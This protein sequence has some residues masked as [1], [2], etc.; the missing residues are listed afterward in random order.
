MSKIF[1]KQLADHAFN[2]SAPPGYANA[3]LVEIGAPLSRFKL[4]TE[5]QEHSDYIVVNAP[6]WE[7]IRARYGGLEIQLWQRNNIYGLPEAIE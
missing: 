2:S 1:V 4:R 6:E 5:L 3:D 7:K